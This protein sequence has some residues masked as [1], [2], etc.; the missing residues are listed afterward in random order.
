MFFHRCV[1]RG[2]LFNMLHE[3]PGGKKTPACLTTLQL[4]DTDHFITN[5]NG[6]QITLILHMD[7]TGGADIDTGTAPDA[8]PFYG[9]YKAVPSPILQFEG[10]DTHNLPTDPNAQ[11]ATN[12]AIGNRTQRYTVIFRQSPDSSGL[13]RHGQQMMKS[14]TSCLFNTFALGPYIQAFS[15]LYDAGKQNFRFS[16]PAQ[17]LNAA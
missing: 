5:G 3:F 1:V 14:K 8:D 2:L 15:D 12:T 9:N 4:I 17:H 13:G 10:P 11:T 16:R 6:P 7:G